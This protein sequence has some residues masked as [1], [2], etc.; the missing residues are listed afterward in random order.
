MKPRRPL[1]QVQC[2]LA[3][4]DVCGFAEPGTL[5]VILGASGAGKSSL[6]NAIADRVPRT[7]GGELSGDLLVNG[8]QADANHRRA[9]QAIGTSPWD[10]Q[11]AYR[12]VCCFN[13][14][15]VSPSLG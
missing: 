12:P 8:V 15:A 2:S 11:A 5:T 6:L 1:P 14:V 7:R 13:S 10:G 3:P 9:G 4:Q